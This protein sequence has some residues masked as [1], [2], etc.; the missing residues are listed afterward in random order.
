SCT[1]VGTSYISTGETFLSLIEAGDGTSWSI[2]TSPNTGTSDFLNGVACVSSGFC[3]AVGN[4]FS[5][6]FPPGTLV[7]AWN[8]SNWSI[9]SSPNTGTGD[10][11]S[12]VACVSSESCTAVGTLIESRNGVRWSIVASPNS[13]HSCRNGVACIAVKSSKSATAGGGHAGGQ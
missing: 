3:T 7:E 11:L 1:A 9:V 5:S 4:Y 8:G 10:F 6:D 13:G 12:G 2:V